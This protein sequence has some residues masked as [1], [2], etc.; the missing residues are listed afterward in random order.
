MKPII[1]LTFSLA[2][3]IISPNP[4]LDRWQ[5]RYRAAV[6]ANL[7]AYLPANPQ[8]SEERALLREICALPDSVYQR[9]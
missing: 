7:E 6:R 9:R 1:F 4:L 8:S 3:V 2:M 5:A